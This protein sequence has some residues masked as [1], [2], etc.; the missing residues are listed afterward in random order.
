MKILQVCPIFPPRPSDFASGVTQVVYQISRELVKRGHKVEVWAANTLDMKTKI[1]DKTTLVDGI[2]VLYFPYIMHHYTF[3]LTPSLIPVVRRNLKDFDVVHIHDFRTFQAIVI[4]NHAK[5]IGVPYVLQ[6]HGAIPHYGTS[7]GVKK[8][9]DIFQ[10]RRL[11]RNASKVIALTSMEVEQYR[12]MGVGVDKIEVVPNGIAP[13]LL[14]KVPKRGDFRKR[15]GIGTEEKL[16]LYLGRIH[17]R[18][19][20]DLL[21]RVFSSL[22]DSLKLRLIIIGMDDGYLSNVNELIAKLG[23][24]EHVMISTEPP[25]EK[26]KLAI[27]T[28]SDVH[29]LPAPYEPFGLT[30]LEAWA[31]GTPVVT[32]DTGGIA[33]WVNNHGGYC[34][35]YDEAELRRAILA[36]ITN[37]ELRVKLGQGGRK[38]V[39]EQFTWDKIAV[40]LEKL[41]DEIADKLV[42]TT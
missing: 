36:L 34:V 41:Y 21:I 19:G 7:Q 17:Q 29:V 14:S 9:Y 23:I 5:E 22:P 18:K 20:L 37:E 39:I 42:I 25:S 13:N 32:I 26:D 4:A 27:Y 40:Q 30:V 11:L 1:R 24:T 35:P 8:L 28:D 2:E 6:A 3:F 33:N 15:Q 10:G 16:I 38:L 31:C 12:N